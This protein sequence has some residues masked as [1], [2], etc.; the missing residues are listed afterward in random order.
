M[1][2]HKRHRATR[3]LTLG[4]LLDDSVIFQRL[5][6]RFP[7]TLP[8]LFEFKGR[9]RI[10]SKVGIQK[11]ILF[12]SFDRLTVSL[13]AGFSLRKSRSG[14]KR[15]IH[16]QITVFRSGFSFTKYKTVSSLIIVNVMERL[17]ILFFI[18]IAFSTFFIYIYLHTD[19]ISDYI[20]LCASSL[21]F[22][23]SVLFQ[24]TLSCYNLVTRLIDVWKPHPCFK[25]TCAFRNS[26]Y[27][28]AQGIWA[29]PGPE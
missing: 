8:D 23:A 26:F 20:I 17:V 10:S 4:L 5:Y 2:I 18:F 3:G 19:I 16:V 14:R 1:N 28:S 13:P 27:L 12:V 11:P 7:W 29:L 24:V 15:I 9:G 22:N 25:S 6:R 21:I